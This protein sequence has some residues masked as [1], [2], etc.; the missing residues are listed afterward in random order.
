MPDATNSLTFTEAFVAE[1][2][3]REANVFFG[4]NLLWGLGSQPVP[5]AES[6]FAGTLPV[7]VGL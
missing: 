6:F 1:T 2:T 4:G 7:L 3:F 5:S